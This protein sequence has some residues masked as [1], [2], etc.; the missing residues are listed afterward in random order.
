MSYRNEKHKA[1][2]EEMTAKMDKQNFALLSALYLLTADHRLWEIMKQHT[3][4]NKVD[5]AGVSLK[6]I[7]EN[8]YTL[9]CVAKDLYLG[10]KHLSVSDLADTELI[11]PQMFMLVCNA[12]A[13][14]RFG[15]KAI[16]L[17]ERGE[18]VTIHLRRKFVR[19]RPDFVMHKN[20]EC[21]KK[22]L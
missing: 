15:M 12:M 11:R 8:G 9:Y 5:F 7:H 18:K 3:Q 17:A 6:G 10:T 20:L 21:V 4:K 22:S 13:V 1:V 16:R 19:T 2:F 14:R